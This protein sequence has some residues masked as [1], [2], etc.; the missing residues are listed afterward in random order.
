MTHPGGAT[1]WLVLESWRLTLQ[2][3]R[4]CGRAA[5][6]APEWASMAPGL[7]LWQQNELLLA[8][9]WVSTARKWA[10]VALKRAP[11][12]P[13][14]LYGFRSRESPWLLDKSPWLHVEPQKLQREPCMLQKELPWPQ[15][16]LNASR[17]W[18][19]APWRQI[20]QDS[21]WVWLQGEPPLLLGESLWLQGKSSWLKDESPWLLEESHDCLVS[22]QDSTASFHS[23][24]VSMNSGEP[25]RLYCNPRVSNGSCNTF[26][27]SFAAP[28]RVSKAQ[29]WASK[30]PGWAF[31]SLG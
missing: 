22:L 15:E 27:M 14:E 30:S 9:G 24:R 23:S 6:A 5:S 26:R 29:G 12:L 1:L 2:S 13:N 25:S 19:L 11:W 21:M 18:S 8:S 17:L 28:G 10:S 31:T 20:H 3:P 16:N 4:L 7:N